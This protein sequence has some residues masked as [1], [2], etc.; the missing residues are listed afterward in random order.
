MEPLCKNSRGNIDTG[1]KMDTRV[2]GGDIDVIDSSGS[3]DTIHTGGTRYRWT[4]DVG[5]VRDN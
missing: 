4:W 1:G 3:K 2:T 5:G